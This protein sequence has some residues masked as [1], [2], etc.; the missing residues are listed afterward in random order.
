MA[1]SGPRGA[2]DSVW[3]VVTGKGAAAGGGVGS[4]G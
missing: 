2:N 4:L 3:G 1:G